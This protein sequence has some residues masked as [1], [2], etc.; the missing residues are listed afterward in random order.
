MPVISLY[1]IIKNA[2]D[3]GFDFF[4]ALFNWKLYSSSCSSDIPSILLLGKHI[5]LF[6]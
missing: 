4:I 5:Q 1:F 3:L 6:E 2:Q